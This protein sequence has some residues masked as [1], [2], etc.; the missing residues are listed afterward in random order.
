MSTVGI[1]RSEP[2]LLGKSGVAIALLE[3]GTPIWLPKWTGDNQP[4]LVFRKHLIYKELK[5]TVDY[6]PHESYQSLLSGVTSEFIIHLKN[7]K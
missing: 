5:K 6:P 4:E 3:H 2:Y 1:V 7:S